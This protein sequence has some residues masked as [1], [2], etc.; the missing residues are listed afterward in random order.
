MENGRTGEKRGEKR[1]GGRKGTVKQEEE[2]E[3][4]EEVGWKK[5]QKIDGHRVSSTGYT[6]YTNDKDESNFTIT[7]APTLPLFPYSL[8][9]RL[10]KHAGVL[11]N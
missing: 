8:S 1:A 6:G 3:K 7:D 11:N 10:Q 5:K 4:Q 9:L 2:E